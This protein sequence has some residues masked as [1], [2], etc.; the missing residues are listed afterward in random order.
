MGVCTTK[1]DPSNI[2]DRIQRVPD[3][4]MFASHA[5]RHDAKGTG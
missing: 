1:N 4:P 5:G 3:G 2:S